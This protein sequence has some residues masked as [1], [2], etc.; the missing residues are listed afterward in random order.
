MK[1]LAFIII[2]VM[3]VAVA[4]FIGRR[5][6]NDTRGG[7]NSGQ[8][9]IASEVLKAQMF[10]SA[11]TEVT[12]SQTVIQQL[13][14]GRIDDAKQ[15]LRT[16]QDGCIFALESALDAAAISTEDMA[17]L[18]D[19]NTSLQSPH[20]SRRDTANRILARVA[21]DRADHPWTYRGDLPHST[22]PEVEAKL[23]SILKRASESQK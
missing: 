17:A 1:N 3:L 19:L 21:Q 8:S 13:D 10:N 5:T 15:M 11:Y 22:D 7:G 16:H 9:G 20:R 12:L 14:S 18:R 4:W 2:A 23:A 6:A